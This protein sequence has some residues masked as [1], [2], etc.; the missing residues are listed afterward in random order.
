M[1]KATHIIVMVTGIVFA[2]GGMNHGIFEILQGNTPTDGFFIASIGEAQRMWVHGEEGAFTIIPNFLYTGIAAVLT[3]IAI[4]IWSIAYLK[5]PRGPIVFLG[6]FIVLFLV[7]GGVAQVIFFTVAYAAATRIHKPLTFW[8]RTLPDGLRRVLASSWR[9]M[10][11]I[12]TGLGFFNLWVATTGHI[13]GVEGDGKVLT[14]MLI[15]LGVWYLMFLLTF[16]AG[17]A[18][19]LEVRTATDK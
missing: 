5:T 1:N 12:T 11:I 14:V 16:V 15:T 3:A 18:H 8:R 19:D 10:L 9:C 6:L 17:F 7:G 4:M 2:I 13:T